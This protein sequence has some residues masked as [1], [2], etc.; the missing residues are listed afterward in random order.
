MKIGDI[1]VFDFHIVLIYRTVLI[2]SSASHKLKTLIYRMFVRYQWRIQ[3]F[4][5]GGA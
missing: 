5:E 2:D 1:N 4:P 3:D